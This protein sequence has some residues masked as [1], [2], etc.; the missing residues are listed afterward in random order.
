ML[1]VFHHM[2]LYLT[3]NFVLDNFLCCKYLC[4]LHICNVAHRIETAYMSR[5][6]TTAL[7]LIFRRWSFAVGK[8]SW[9]FSRPCSRFSHWWVPSLDHQPLTTMLSIFA[10]MSAFI[11]LAHSLSQLCEYLLTLCIRYIVNLLIL[12]ALNQLYALH[13][14][15]RRR[16]SSG[17]YV[18]KDY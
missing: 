7:T 10:L 2:T 5:G 6:I 17:C 1:C 13:T 8:H 3:L 15:T 18:S 9:S 16:K 11:R 14:V 4:L 12:Q